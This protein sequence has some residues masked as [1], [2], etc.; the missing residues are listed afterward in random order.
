MAGFS[1]ELSGSVL[2]QSGN[3]V[4][5]SLV[6]GINALALTGS[7]NITGSQLTFNGQDIIQ[8]FESIEAGFVGSASLYDLNQH[9]SSINDFTASVKLFTG[10]YNS[11]S[12]SQHTTITDI[13]G[14][15]NSL[16]TRIG[17]L[18]LDNTNYYSSSQQILADGF[19][20][21]SN[22]DIISS[23]QQLTELG[24][25]TS[26]VA[27]IP[28][29]TVSSSRQISNLGFITSSESA[30]FAT[31]ASY[32]AGQNVDGTVD[33][34]VSASYALTAS[35]IDPL[36]IS[37]SAVAAGFGEGGSDIPAGTI[38]SS[39]Q[40][41]NL[42]FITSSTEND[43]IAIGIINSYTS[44]TDARLA[45]L[46]AATS[47]YSTGSH[48]SIDAL[49]T[50]TGSYLVDSASFDS[51]LSNIS[52]DTGSL[53]TDSELSALSASAHEARLN[54]TASSVDTGSLLTTA[55]YLTD[56]ASFDT[57]ISSINVPDIDFNGN[58]RVSNTL[59]GD[60]Y[61]NNFNPGTTGT[62]QQF[63]DAVFFPSVAPTATFTDQTSI[64]NANQAI[65]GSNLISVLISDTVDES[66]YTL[67]LSGAGASN[68]VAVPQNAASSSW[69]ITAGSDLS[70][71]VYAFTVTVGDNVGST[72]SY[73]K[74]ISIAEANSGA[75]STNGT[76]YIIESAT[77]GPIYLNSNGRTGTQGQVSVTYTPNY[78]SQVA[79]NFQSS[80]SLLSIDTFGRLSVGDPISGS[81]N[82]SGD[83]ISSNISWEDQYGNSASSSISVLVTTNNAPIITE[84]NN[85]TNLNTNLATSGSTLVTITFSD[86][87]GDA[88]NYDSFTFTN[89]SGELE[90]VRNG[91]TF[92]VRP[93]TNLQAS[94][95]N[96][97]STVTDEHGFN[98]RTSN[99]TFTVAQAVNGTLVGDTNI[100]II[101]SAL[102]GSVFRDATGYNNGNAADVGVSYIPNYGSQVAT[103]TSSNPAIAINSA[104]NLSLAVDLSGSLTQSGDT[105]STI[106][107]WTD[108]YGNTDNSVINATVFGNQS[109]SATLVVNEYNNDQA[110]S[111]STVATLVISDTESNTPFNVTL[112][113]ISG[114]LFN[115]VP[116]NSISSSWFIQPT[117]SLVPGSYPISLTVTD[118]Y[119]EQSIVNGTIEIT[120][121]ATDMLYVY[122]VGQATSNYNNDLGIASQ[123][124]D[125]PPVASSYGGFGFLEK[126]EDGDLGSTS[127][128]Y[129]WG[130]SKTA[131]LLASAAGANVND[132]LTNFSTISKTNSNRFV[133]IMPS[134]S[135]MTGV[136]R[137]MTDQYGGSDTD[138]YVL[139]VGADGTAIGSGL[140]TTEASNIHKINLTTPVNGVSDYIMIG[141]QNTIATATSIE[142]RIIP[143]SGSAS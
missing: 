39:L 6:P 125:I 13:R 92:L 70:A 114:S 129:D 84:T 104:G 115:A 81:S 132:I 121:A 96:F 141:A 60:L 112:S 99:H 58:R 12:A 27:D 90:A 134:G 110:I 113:G 94:S 18:E 78:G 85:N 117:G 32:V 136:P 139:E 40:I 83:Q 46:E 101:E 97:T 95:Y 11:D 86:T 3:L 100:Y 68:L 53:V 56:S 82:V 108:Q 10:S 76:F 34:S 131:T 37:A 135:D 116:Q 55:S 73:N 64:W 4:Q 133:I 35:Y 14:D 28:A 67:I 22:S 89:T 51:R 16:N 42:G 17:S 59:L 36:F 138:E 105:F 137:T 118:N 19:L 25:V 126:I 2:F 24:F 29:G 106:V 71:G 140:G 54:I 93:F 41:S 102:S 123:T 43:T 38:S 109:P 111:G 63:L 21:S 47:S 5:A 103:F 72:R 57:R 107:T 143:E 120:A 8:R 45:A 142:L 74:T 7:F 15:I 9:S 44:S 127:F 50:F 31:T 23:S 130:G 79:T 65:S 80:N 77:S 69:E 52:I 33:L 26:S 128:T 88:I 119:S 61:T 87:E 1:T 30:S 62:I 48:V 49:N 122:D 75:L 20:T 66:P 91:T 124:S 98:T